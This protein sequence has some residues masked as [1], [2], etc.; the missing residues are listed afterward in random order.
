KKTPTMGGV[1]PP[2]GPPLTTLGL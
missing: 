1:A 2:R